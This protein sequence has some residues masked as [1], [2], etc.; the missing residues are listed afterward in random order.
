MLKHLREPG[1]QVKG[2]RKAVAQGLG[3]QGGSD[4]R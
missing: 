4:Q 2:L 3:M 1:F